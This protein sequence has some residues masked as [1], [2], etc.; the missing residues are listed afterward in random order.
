M[1]LR[2]TT[3]GNSAGVVLPKELLARLRVEKGD[4]LYVTELPDGIKL[5]AYDP[6]FAQQ[7]AVAEQIMRED[8]TVLR[9][10]ADS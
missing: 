6:T 5:Q 1:K 7:M 2:I 9:R 8:R 10:L 3:V 4:T